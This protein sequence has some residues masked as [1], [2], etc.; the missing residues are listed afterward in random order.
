MT[1]DVMNRKGKMQ[2]I[3]NN[4]VFVEFINGLNLISKLIVRWKGLHVE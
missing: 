3:Q 4:L 2:S 1:K